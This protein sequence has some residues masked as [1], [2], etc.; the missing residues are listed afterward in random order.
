MTSISLYM[1]G[2][3][4]LAYS[5]LVAPLVLNLTHC[6]HNGQ[7][8]AGKVLVGG[9]RSIREDVGLKCARVVRTKD[10]SF[11]EMASFLKEAH[12]GQCRER[13]EGCHTRDDARGITLSIRGRGRAVCVVS[14]RDLGHATRLAIVGR[15]RDQV[16]IIKVEGKERR[17]DDKALSL[18]NSLQPRHWLEPAPPS[19]HHPALAVVSAASHPHCGLSGHWLCYTRPLFVP[20]AP[21]AVVC[22]CPRTVPRS[23]SRRPDGRRRLP[24]IPGLL[25]R[26]SSPIGLC[27]FP[28]HGRPSA[29]CGPGMAPR[30]SSRLPFRPPPARFRWPACCGQG[31]SVLVPLGRRPCAPPTPPA[32]STYLVV[33]EPPT[34]GT[35]RFA[36][37]PRAGR[38]CRCPTPTFRG[39]DHDGGEEEEKGPRGDGER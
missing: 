37:G 28:P 22:I 24:T 21:A 18:T 8:N 25:T 32:A 34:V 30:F 33:D 35:W 11:D 31:A 12:E 38:R 17:D 6:A 23:A 4:K 29:S 10:L 14:A 16:V 3:A 15:R 9:R 39:G 20:S 19:Q 5:W 36:V 13:E 1:G 7:I 26:W 27:I 2:L